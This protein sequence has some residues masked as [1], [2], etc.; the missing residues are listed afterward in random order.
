MNH[1]SDLHLFEGYG[2]EL[3]YM[4]VRS[5]NL[6]VYPVSDRVLAADTGE[7]A[8]EVRRGGLAWSNELVLHVIELKTAG[9]AAELA[10]LPPLFHDAV[11]RINGL[12]GP[13]GGRL[14]PS[15]MHP[16]M[17][18]H[19]E[20]KLW[21]HENSDIYRAYDRIFDCRGHGWSNLQSAHINL[22]FQ[23]DAEFGR[24]HAAVRLVLP[25]I[26]A[27]CA[28]SPLADNRVSPFL[29]T[30][31]H[32]Y[33]NNQRAI[34]SISGPVIP[35][36]VFSE[37]EYRERVFRKM[38][39]DIAPHDPEGVLREEWLNSRAAIPHFER[40]TIEIRVL[41]IQE[42][43]AA[44]LSAAALIIA[45]V[46][47][48]VDGMWQASEA[49]RR[50]ESGPLAELFMKCM[51]HAEEAEIDNGPYLGLFGMKGGKCRA[52]EL[53]Q[54]LS[55]SL[56]AEYP[57]LGR[58]DRHLSV[59]LSKGSLARRILRALEGDDDPRKIFAVYGRLCDCLRENVMFAG[60]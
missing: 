38:F 31:L 24:L 11:T 60:I 50:W 52:G 3:E 19:R 27:L 51:T 8:G 20:A 58:W 40:N 15:A 6:S 44:D 5:D 25:I 18:P 14:M 48:L 17:D 57:E 41:D 30:R 45:L 54:H 12:L 56:A 34:P 9:P 32:H 53:W 39:D 7:P 16:W 35:E 33:M 59:M 47:S 21:P 28:S 37:R 36:P 26:P 23:G 46:R 2:I 13:M 55:E 22:P 1:P 43:P 49:Q 4:I 10:A 42:C 29:D